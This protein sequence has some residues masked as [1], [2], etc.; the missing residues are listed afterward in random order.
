VTVREPQ[1][2]TGEVLDRV[3][4]GGVL[5]VTA[6]APRSRRCTRALAVVFHQPT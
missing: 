6:T 1:N 4:P 5:I 3:A 2:H